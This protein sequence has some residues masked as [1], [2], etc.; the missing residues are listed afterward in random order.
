[1]AKSMTLGVIMTADVREGIRLAALEERRSSSALVANICEDW[2]RARASAKGSNPA[3]VSG[4]PHRSAK[5]KPR[6]LRSNPDP[7]RKRRK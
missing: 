4:L 7:V 3:T 5:D 1:M 2:L 6:V